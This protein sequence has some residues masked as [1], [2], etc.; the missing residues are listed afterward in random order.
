[1][2]KI[3]IHSATFQPTIKE[4]PTSMLTELAELPGKPQVYTTIRNGVETI[5]RIKLYFKEVDG[6]IVDGNLFRNDDMSWIS[7]IVVTGKMTM[8]TKDQ[9][10]NP[11]NRF[12]I[13]K[14]IVEQGYAS[15]VR[16]PGS[17]NR[18]RETRVL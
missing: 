8:R 17:T 16:F 4:W 11:R 3:F 1:M 14:Y 15:P 10:D 13:H 6:E 12:R 2:K 7:E 18:K 5:S 9:R